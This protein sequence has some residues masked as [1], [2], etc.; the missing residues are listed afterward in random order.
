MSIP[1][2]IVAFG[3]TSLARSTYVHLDKEIQQHFPNREIIWTYSSKILSRQLDQDAKISENNPEAVFHRLIDQGHQKIVVQSLHLLAGSAFHRLHQET[4]RLAIETKLGM[5][6]LH[7]PEDYQAIIRMLGA[8]ITSHPDCAILV[9]GH[10][11]SHPVWPA[12]LALENLLQ[13]EYGE[14]ILVGVVEK[15]P[16]TAGLIE[17][18]QASGFRRVVMIPF[19]LV[20]GMHYRRDMNGSGTTS[21]R[22]RLLAAGLAVESMEQGLGMLPGMGD[23]IARHI[24]EAD[25]G[26]AT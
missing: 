19:L 11:T 23:L 21:W 16:S 13:A 18:I 25:A 22:S 9:V 24:V 12:Y 4:R 6:L 3:T 20:A 5:P 26:F 17:R 14:R 1:I 2:V 10:G 8:C 7:T 15:Y